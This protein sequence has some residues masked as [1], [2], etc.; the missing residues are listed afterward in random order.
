MKF[1]YFPINGQ[2]QFR[3][4]VSVTQQPNTSLKK[5]TFL[6][7]LYVLLTVSTILYISSLEVLDFTHCI[8]VDRNSHFSF[9]DGRV[10]DHVFIF[11]CANTKIAISC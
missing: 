7:I 4:V 1:L 3:P 9:K 11:S 10:E 2:S 8:S 5:S 6:I